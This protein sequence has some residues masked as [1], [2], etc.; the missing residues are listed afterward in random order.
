MSKISEVLFALRKYDAAAKKF[1]D[2]V[3]SGKAHSKETYKDLKDALEESRLVQ[4]DV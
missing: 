1:I 4:E 2:K 3:E